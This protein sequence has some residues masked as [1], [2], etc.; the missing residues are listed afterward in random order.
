M[1]DG[2]FFFLV[3]VTVALGALAWA[4]GGEELLRRGLSDGGFLLWRYAL[5][6]C[7]SFLAAGL[8][9]VVLPE[10]WVRR[11]FG[12]DSGFGGI[13]M[14][15]GVGMVTPA[16]PFVAIPIAAVMIRNGAAAG[17]VVAFVSGWSLLALH[18][19][20][21]WEIPMLGF[22]FAALRYGACLVLPLLAGLIARAVTSR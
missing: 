19:F 8:A 12:A 17:P 10:E 3:A 22:R 1:L 13:V 16:G 14:A 18:R 20:I 9:A 2:T 4:R 11:S 7:I 21:A 15:T 6:I 5:L